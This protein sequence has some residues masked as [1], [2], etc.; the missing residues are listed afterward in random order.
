MINNVPFAGFQINKE[1]NIINF[2]S[3]L[4]ETKTYLLP[5]KYENDYTNN[6]L[7][8]TKNVLITVKVNSHTFTS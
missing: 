8:T 6:S 4:I 5:F 7:A 3:L 2:T 1:R